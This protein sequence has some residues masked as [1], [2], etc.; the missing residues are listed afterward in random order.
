MQTILAAITNLSYPTPPVVAKPKTEMQQILLTAKTG[1]N[2]TSLSGDPGGGSDNQN[3][4]T[5][6]NCNGRCKV[7][8]KRNL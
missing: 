8:V 5:N 4:N 7:S 1:S 6:N 2:S 3:T